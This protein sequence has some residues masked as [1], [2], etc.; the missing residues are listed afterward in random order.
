MRLL[1]GLRWTFVSSRLAQ[2]CFLVNAVR[3]LSASEIA[4]KP[5]KT[6]KK[7]ATFLFTK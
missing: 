4:C 7:T 6:S 3:V 5:V 1:L 2:A